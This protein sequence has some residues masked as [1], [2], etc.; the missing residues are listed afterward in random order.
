MY[1]EY[2]CELIV[3]NENY[4]KFLE[5]L[6]EIDKTI[7]KDSG[8]YTDAL[9]ALSDFHMASEQNDYGDDIIF[10]GKFNEKDRH[11]IDVFESLKNV[12]ESGTL[13][14]L[15]ESFNFYK[16]EIKEGVMNCQDL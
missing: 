15:E 5:V 1:I 3:K 4:C 14:I 9:K 2:K 6:N 11:Q 7:F 16:Y 13:R 10:E 12:V 8:Q